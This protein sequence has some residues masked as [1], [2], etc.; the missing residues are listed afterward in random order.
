M[1]NEEV[2][3]RINEKRSMDDNLREKI[4]VDRSSPKESY[5]G[6]IYN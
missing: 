3:H 6:N 4:E 1:L 2:Y 5:T